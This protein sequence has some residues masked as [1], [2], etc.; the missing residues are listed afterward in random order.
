[1]RQ[2]YAHQIESPEVV[3]A[4]AEAMMLEHGWNTDQGTLGTG[5]E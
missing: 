5:G 1:M 4:M 2:R 3:R